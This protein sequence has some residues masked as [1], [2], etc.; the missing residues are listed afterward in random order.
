MRTLLHE[1]S[2]KIKNMEK[3]TKEEFLRDK[4]NNIKLQ[5]SL[6]N[7]DYANA[8]NF[9]HDYYIFKSLSDCSPELAIFDAI[10][11]KRLDMP[12]WKLAQYCNVSRTTLFKYR[13]EIIKNFNI[14]LTKNFI[15]NQTAFTKG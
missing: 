8:F 4:E 13:N 9:L 7:E 15:D 14:C 5:I 3:V 2:A 6:G 11:I 1:K 10:Y 12:T